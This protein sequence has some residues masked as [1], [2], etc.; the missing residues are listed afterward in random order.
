[1]Y[2]LD[3]RI[4]FYAFNDSRAFQISRPNVSN[5]YNHFYDASV[6]SR[7]ILS[8]TIVDNKATELKENV[9]MA[10]SYSNVR[11]SLINIFYSACCCFNEILA[12]F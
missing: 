9:T 11:F 3:S 5:D 2:F 7:I 12:Y 4:S 10:F 6:Q 8:A 1:M